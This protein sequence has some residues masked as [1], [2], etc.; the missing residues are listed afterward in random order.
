MLQLE[1]TEKKKKK[2]FKLTLFGALV[3]VIVLMTLFRVWTGKED[4]LFDFST[5]TTFYAKTTVGTEPSLRIE[6]YFMAGNYDPA[7][8]WFDLS[9][10]DWNQAGTYLIPVF[11]D[12]K[13]TNCTVQVEVVAPGEKEPAVAEPEPGMENQKIE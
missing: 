3:L 2:R 1:S 10:G 11:Y 12:G 6:D 7:G 5:R 13:E 8:F 4:S 9:R